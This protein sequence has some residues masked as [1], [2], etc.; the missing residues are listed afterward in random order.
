MKP[1]DQHQPLEHFQV[2]LPTYI[3]A[4]LEKKAADDSSFPRTVAR[5]ILIQYF[6]GQQ[7]DD[8]LEG[9]EAALSATL[10][11]HE[12]RL[13]SLETAQ[14][15]LFAAQWALIEMLIRERE[16][17]RAR[18]ALQVD[19]MRAQIA[20]DLGGGSPLLDAVAFGDRAE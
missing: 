18:A 15:S 4:Y 20:R 7:V 10:S 16:P 19:A 11:R 14:Q 1:D 5:N 3:I 2:R 13:R 17:D 8:R 6:Q 12:K 9:I